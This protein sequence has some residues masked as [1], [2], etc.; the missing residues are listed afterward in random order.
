[1]EIP[2]TDVSDGWTLRGRER[3]CAAPVRLSGVKKGEETFFLLPVREEWSSKN[4]CLSVLSFFGRR[5]KRQ[6]RKSIAE[7][8]CLFACACIDAHPLRQWLRAGVSMHRHCPSLPQPRRS[9]ASFSFPPRSS[10]SFQPFISFC[11]YRTHTQPSVSLA[12]RT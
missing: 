11:P 12:I 10:F 9:P 7:T 3:E 6:E 1:M 5:R 4:L 2:S 8:P